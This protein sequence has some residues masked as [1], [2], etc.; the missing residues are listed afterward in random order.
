[1]SIVRS[2]KQNADEQSQILLN[3]N[4]KRQQNFLKE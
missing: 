3:T 1:M 2:N 4:K